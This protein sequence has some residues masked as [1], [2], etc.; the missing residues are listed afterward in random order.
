MGCQ[1]LLLQSA[2]SGLSHL[3]LSPSSAQSS[4]HIPT[5]SQD[6]S[7]H[8]HW[9]D[10]HQ[11]VNALSRK[12]LAFMRTHGIS[13]L[14]AQHQPSPCPWERL[15][16]S[17]PEMGGRAGQAWGVRTGSARL[18]PAVVSSSA[19]HILVIIRETDVCHVSRVTKV[20]LMFGLWAKVNGDS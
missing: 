18:V 19:D 17:T 11:R 8:N 16:H 15:T 5:P 3:S 10:S 2:V 9:V 1:E 4:Y 6:S 20:S 7:S 14:L 13:C 12:V